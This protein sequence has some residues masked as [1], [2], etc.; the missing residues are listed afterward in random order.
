MHLDLWTLALQTINVLVLVWLLAR[1]LFR[2]VAGIIAARRSAADAL[3]ADAETARAK[4][5]AEAA[6]LAQQRQGLADEGGRIVVAARAAAEAERATVLH[7]ADEAAARLHADA[8]QAIAREREQIKESLEH[9]A[10][11]LSV[12]IASRLLERIPSQILNRAFLEGVT[13]MLASHPARASL[14]GAPLEVRSAVTLDP[15]LQAECRAMLARLIGGTPEPD[16]RTD[17]T[18]LAGIEL[19]SPN[20]VIRNSWKDDL[21]RITRALQQDTSH[22]VASPPVA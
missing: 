12:T 18:L 21:E 9:E 1:F 2:P 15:A 4:V 8:R 5:A 11:D 13:E 10:A 16:F 7:Q 19:A 17:P 3:I 6:A 14:L 22:D 20:A